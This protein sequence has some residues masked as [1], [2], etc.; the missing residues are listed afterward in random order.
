MSSYFHAKNS[1]IAIPVRRKLVR[2]ALPFQT[3]ILGAPVQCA[4]DIDHRAF[5]RIPRSVSQTL[6]VAALGTKQRDRRH[7]VIPITCWPVPRKINGHTGQ[8][9]GS[10]R[11]E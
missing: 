4:R 8:Q 7:A 6:L 3:L 1:E 5:Q 10:V 11:T 9:L 2:L